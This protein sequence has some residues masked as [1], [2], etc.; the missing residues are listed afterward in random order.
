MIVLLVALAVVVLVVGV[1][2]WRR[3]GRSAPAVRRDAPTIEATSIERGMGPTRTVLGDRL[4][5]LLRSGPSAEVW[6][7]LEEALIAAD[8]GVATAASVVA[9][10]RDRD[11]GSEGEARATL[12]EELVA[13]FGQRDRTIATGPTPTVIVL[14]GVNGTG[15]TTTAAKLAAL[16]QHEGREPLLAA[17][18]TFRAAAATQLATWADRLGVDI[19][20]GGEGADAASVAYDALQAAT[21]RERGA[22]VVD[23][24]GRLHSKTN[25]MDELRKV[26]RVL[27][28]DGH[29]VA[30]ILLVID[31]TAGQNGIAQARTF[32]DAVGVTGIVITKLDGSARGGAAVAIEDDLGVPVKLVGVGESVEDLLH[33]DPADF[34]DAL[35][36]AT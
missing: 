21:A 12:R 17:A 29:P 19:V 27:G 13:V 10:V 25:L 30:E 14:V 9:R 1:L 2:W 11:P 20:A 34:V 36:G 16:L 31:G 3:R 5:S 6:T 22:L 33:F 35:L 28:R 7:G 18:D 4:S 32:L 8:V 26:V 15:K 23:T 24:A